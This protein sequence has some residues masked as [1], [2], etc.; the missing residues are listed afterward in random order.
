MLGSGIVELAVMLSKL[1]LLFNNRLLRLIIE[2][3]EQA[4]CVVGCELLPD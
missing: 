4:L 2:L 3:H 1:L